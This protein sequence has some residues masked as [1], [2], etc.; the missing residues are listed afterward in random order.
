MNEIDKQ[1]NEL[2][3]LA[4]RLSD[5]GAR[6]FEIVQKADRVNRDTYDPDVFSMLGAWLDLEL[7]AARSDM[8]ADTITGD[9]DRARYKIQTAISAAADELGKERRAWIS[10]MNARFDQE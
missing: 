9:F 3:T 2:E 7:Q 6:L 4:G 10:A 1:L 5:A 8:A